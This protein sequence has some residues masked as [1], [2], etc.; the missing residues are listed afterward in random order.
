L[1]SPYASRQQQKIS[2]KIP[3]EERFSNH[4]CLPDEK[5]KK[6]TQTPE[7]ESIIKFDK[8]VARRTFYWMSSCSGR[9]G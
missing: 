2:K 4:G 1:F 7:A 8:N 3:N 5:K 6:C 9:S